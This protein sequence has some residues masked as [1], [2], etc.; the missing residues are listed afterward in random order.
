MTDLEVTIIGKNLS[1]TTKST[2]FITPRLDNVAQVLS[3]ELN[4]SVI[5]MD[6]TV[7]HVDIP[8]YIIGGI[9]GNDPGYEVRIAWDQ[10]F[11]IAHILIVGYKLKNGLIIHYTYKISYVQDEYGSGYYHTTDIYDRYFI[12]PNFYCFKAGIYLS[13]KNV[14]TIFGSFT[15]LG[16]K[17]LNG[18][19][20]GYFNLKL[21]PN[22]TKLKLSSGPY[23]NL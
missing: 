8:P 16:E 9:I 19:A 20:N 14:M 4:Q 13:G 7:E 21:S 22:E 10:S 5:I 1:I 23:P 3:V 12:D 2:R 6:G 15:E 18:G 17:V 11:K